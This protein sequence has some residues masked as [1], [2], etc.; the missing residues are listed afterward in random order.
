MWCNLQAELEA[1]PDRMLAAR[2]GQLR[3]LGSDLGFDPASRARLGVTKGA[4]PK[5]G[6]EKFLT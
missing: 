5:E 6:A 1:A 4:K 2:I 3:A